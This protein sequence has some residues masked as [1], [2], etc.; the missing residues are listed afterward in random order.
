MFFKLRLASEHAGLSHHHWNS[1]VLGVRVGHISDDG[2]ACFIMSDV[3]DRAVKWEHLQCK[4]RP[5]TNPRCTKPLRPL[6]SGLAPVL[7][8]VGLL[9]TS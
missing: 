6:R 1:F 3:K 8:P 2:F 7:V 5:G 9:S 4:Q